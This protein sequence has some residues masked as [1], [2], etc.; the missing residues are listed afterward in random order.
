MAKPFSHLTGNGGHFHMSLWDESGQRDLF[1][2]PSDPN[3]LGLSTLGYHFLGGL[4]STPRRTS[5][6][7]LRP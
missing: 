5:R 4:T 1:D 6:S 7:R 2:D 3:G